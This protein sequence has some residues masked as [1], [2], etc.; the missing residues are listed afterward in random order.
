MTPYAFRGTCCFHLQGWWVYTG[1]Q[2]SPK[3]RYISTGLHDDLSYPVNLECHNPWLLQNYIYLWSSSAF[4]FK[5]TSVFL[6]GFVPPAVAEISFATLPFSGA[7]TISVSF[8][9]MSGVTVIY[10]KSMDPAKLAG[11]RIGKYQ[12]FPFYSFQPSS[13]KGTK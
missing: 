6:L 10:W 1:H 3:C 5:R 8:C 12:S 9:N 2:V 13:T 4:Y 11:L 7:H